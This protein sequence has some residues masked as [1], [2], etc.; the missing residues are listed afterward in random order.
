M[1]GQPNCSGSSD[2]EAFES[3]DEIDDYTDTKNIAPSPTTTSTTTTKTLN[4]DEKKS[5]ASTSTTHP[6]NKKKDIK[7]N[8]NVN[9]N[10]FES[11][12]TEKQFAEKIKSI[13][14]KDEKTSV[15]LDT[16]AK[17]QQEKVD[18]SSCDKDNKN[19]SDGWD[20][21]DWG[22]IDDDNT[23]EESS[24]K[25]EI[26]LDHKSNTGQKQNIDEG[27]GW[28]LD[29]WDLLSSSASTTKTTTKS[30]SDSNQNYISLLDKLSSNK[31]TNSSHHQIT[32]NYDTF[33]VLNK[34]DHKKIQSHIDD[35]KNNESFNKSLNNE[36][37]PGNADRVDGA[38]SGW[39]VWK[40]WENVVSLLSTAGSGVAS[41]TSQVTQVIESG[42]GVPDPAE[43]AR[44]QQQQDKELESC[45]TKTTSDDLQQSIKKDDNN[46]SILLENFVYNFQNI[47]NKVLTGG[48][49]TLEGIGKKTMTILKENDRGLLN[50]RYR[51]FIKN[52]DIVLSQV[53]FF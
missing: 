36:I 1:S 42:I 45:S 31:S 9:N 38:V 11:N 15:N 18:E 16:A 26:K 39:G 28:N 49:D 34:L 13:D 51:S 7:L 4:I 6:N 52:D 48:L 43:M 17:V 24:S 30:Q 14:I 3:A 2:S 19:Q 41:L 12:E 47:G 46:K 22:D 37:I 35:D 5:L 23:I 8:E 20:V 32:S 33:P 53:R 40:P 50:K 44:L 29:D 25:Q 21:D 27:E 10:K